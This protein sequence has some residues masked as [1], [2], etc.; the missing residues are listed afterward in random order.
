MFT[1]SICTGFDV[2]V[3]KWIIVIYVLVNMQMNVG[4][5]SLVTVDKP[6]FPMECVSLIMDFA[7]VLYL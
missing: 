4:G 1:K 5:M 2:F 7:W 3:D 6:A